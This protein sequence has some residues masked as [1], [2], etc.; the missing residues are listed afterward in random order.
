[1]CIYV[2]RGATARHH[3]FYTEGGSFYKD[4][5]DPG[6]LAAWQ[7]AKLQVRNVCGEFGYESVALVPIRLGL[8]ILGLIHVADPR[9]QAISAHTVEALEKA[10]MQ[11]GTAIQRVRAEEALRRCATSWK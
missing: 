2:V 4:T 5:A 3:A 9:Q 8:R 7:E 6:F 11:L 10:A 1:M